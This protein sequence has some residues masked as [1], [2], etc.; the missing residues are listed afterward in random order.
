SAIASI[1]AADAERN[2]AAEPASCRPETTKVGS[3]L[4]EEGGGRDSCG[5]GGLPAVTG[6]HVYAACQA[7]MAGLLN[8]LLVRSG[9]RAADGK[10]K[11]RRTPLHLAV[12]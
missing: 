7:G 6:E 10:D 12:E 5:G 8:D 4:S 3:E 1:P 2:E 9:G 11:L